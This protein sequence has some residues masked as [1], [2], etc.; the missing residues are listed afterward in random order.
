MGKTANNQMSASQIL[1]VEDDPRVLELYRRVLTDFKDVAY[2]DH[3]DKAVEFIRKAED[4]S[5]ALVDFNLPG[6]SGL[7]IIKEMKTN[8]PAAE[9]VVVTGIDEVDNAVESIRAGAANYITKPFDPDRIA[10]IAAKNR[11]KEELRREV[12]RLRRRLDAGKEGVMITGQSRPM[13]R[14]LD[15]VESISGLDPIVL[16]MGET[17]TGKDLLARVVHEQSS[18][19]DQ[20]FIVTDCAVLSERLIESDLFGHEK[21]AFTDARSQ[22][23]GKFERADGGTLFLNEIG[24]LSSPAQAKLLRVIE[25]GELERLGGSDTIKVDVRV[26]AATNED[27]EVEVERGNFRS[28]LFYRIN[29]VILNLPPLRERLE[30]IPLLSRFFLEQYCRRYSKPVEGI[31]DEVYDAFYSYSWPGNI[32]ELENVIDRAVITA[33]GKSLTA[34]DI[35]PLISRRQ[36]W[37]RGGGV[38][39]T[40]GRKREKT[41][42]GHAEK[43]RL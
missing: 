40:P 12:S 23:K 4:I 3:G 14:I 10:A 8:F 24:T 16:I 29:T 22:R 39:M 33:S 37:G 36:R 27:L 6:A 11:E 25:D 5:L 17:G 38:G 34:G 30:D 13:R 1:V 32:R 31:D 20:P 35:R 15:T 41:D 19:S 2:L 7:E 9:I 42:R 21:G 28:D 43:S 18:R 26:I